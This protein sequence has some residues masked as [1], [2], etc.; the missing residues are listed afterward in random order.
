LDLPKSDAPA[1]SSPKDTLNISI[2]AKGEL[3]LDR[4]PITREALTATLEQAA[5]RSRQTPIHLRAERDTRY[6]SVVEVMA[7]A[8]RLGL[9]QLAFVTDLPTK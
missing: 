1:V 4:K 8:N 2:T 3:F 9:S 6:E 7:M 5:S